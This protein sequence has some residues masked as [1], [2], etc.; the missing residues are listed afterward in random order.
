MLR[1]LVSVLIVFALMAC[2]GAMLPSPA[3][4]AAPMTV[5]HSGG[6]AGCMH[7]HAPDAACHDCPMCAGADLPRL[8]T[9]DDRAPKQPTLQRQP[10]QVT[11]L[12]GVRP[13]NLDRPPRTLG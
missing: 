13:A 11:P 5:G 8:A 12:T 10:A 1:R 7:H 6:H 3:Q 4:A 2:F 9:W